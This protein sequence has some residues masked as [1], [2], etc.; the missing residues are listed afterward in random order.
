MWYMI[1]K[2]NQKNLEKTSETNKFGGESMQKWDRVKH[3]I[4]SL[5][6]YIKKQP[7]Q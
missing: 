5:I 1:N 6:F 2:I 7:S 4:F 3:E